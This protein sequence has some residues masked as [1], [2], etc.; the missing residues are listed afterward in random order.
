MFRPFA[1]GFLASSLL[2]AAVD[3]APATILFAGRAHTIE[4]RSDQGALWIAAADFSRIFDMQLKPEGVCYGDVCLPIPKG[5]RE[6]LFQG[7]SVDALGLAKLLDQAVAAEPKASAWAFG[8]VPARQR[9]LFE[10]AAA[11]D[12]E[13]TDRKGKKI[14]LSDYR[15]KKVF[16]FTWASWCMCREDL[17]G[18]QALYEELRPKGLE[19]ISAAQDSGGEAAAGKFFDKA[20]T[21]FPAVVDPDHTISSLYHMVN[22]PTGVWIDEEGKMVRPPEVSYTKT[23]SLVK[24][25]GAKY[26]AGLRDW[27]ARGKESPYAMSPEQLREK[28]NI[29]PQS[30]EQADAEFKLA[31]YFHQRNNDEAARRHF[32]E[33]ERLNPDSWNYHRQEWS[34]DP[35]SANG[36]WLRKVR[37]LGGKDYYAPLE[38]PPAS[39]KP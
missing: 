9:T 33:A 16:L 23:V 22:V 30:L 27:V 35:K 7:A 38:F 36:K 5:Q 8:P 17:P 34:F 4:A 25:E 2:A 18:W 6:R 24:I 20:K 15:G 1:L 31:V 28:L 26:T 21:T 32:A 3:A 39:T 13:L 37:S 11:P 19:I 10:S 14:R 12:F 29:R